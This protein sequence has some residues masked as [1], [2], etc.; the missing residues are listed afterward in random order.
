[1]S[2]RWLDQTVMHE[3]EQGRYGNCMQACVASLLN[4]PL[5][6]VPHFHEDGCDVETFWERVED[7][8]ADRHYLLRYGHPEKT[9]CIASGKTVRGTNHCVIMRDAELI[10]DPHPSRV[11]IIR[12]T[13]RMYL[14]PNDP[15]QK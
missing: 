7:W 4:L 11:G 9:L 13:N 5:A 1:M 12:E 6:D 14:L 10:H 8:L 15:V 3:P 2:S